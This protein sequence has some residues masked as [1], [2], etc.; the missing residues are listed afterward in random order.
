MARQGGRGV[1]IFPSVFTP[2]WSSPRNFFMKKNPQHQ[3]DKPTEPPIAEPEKAVY[4]A[5]ASKKT[6]NPRLLWVRIE[7]MDGEVL[8]TVRDNTFYRANERLKVER[9]GEGWVDLHPK[10]NALL[11]GGQE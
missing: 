10:T 2:H 11:R 6:L 7:G 8:V 5:R 1:S 9:S 3:A 4:E